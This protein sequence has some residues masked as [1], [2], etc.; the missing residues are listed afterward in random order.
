[1]IFTERELAT[2]L[3]GLRLIQCGGRLEGCAVADCEHFADDDILTDNEIDDLCEQ[4]N[5]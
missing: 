2:I 4:I 5:V 1:M 3:H